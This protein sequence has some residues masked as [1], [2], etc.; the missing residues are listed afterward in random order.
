[1]NAIKIP[2]ILLPKN[3]DMELWA[4]NACDQFTSDKKYWAQLDALI[5]DNP[6]TLRLIFPEIYL[7]NKPKERIDDINAHMRDYLY[8]GIFEEVQ[9][10]FIL[11]ERTTQ[12]GKRTGIV[13]A[14]DLEAY[15]FNEGSKALIRSTEATI[16]E[17]IPPRV[18]IREN[19]P[20]ELPHVMLLYDDKE[21]AVLSTVR[22]GKVLYY[23]ELNMDGGHVKGTY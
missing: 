16:L 1:M 8:G 15:D 12:S 11:V 18:K 13:L 20:I 17:R 19:A 4:V 2:S 7:K 23:F 14:I 9:G 10:G 3:V 22:R 5:G 21:G 6:S